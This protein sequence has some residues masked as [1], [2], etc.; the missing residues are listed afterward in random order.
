MK[1]FKLLKRWFNMVTGKSSFHVKQGEGKY[2]SKYEIKGYY[3]DL[4]NKVSNKTVIDSNGIPINTTIANLETYFPIS[5]FQ[6]GLGLY[7]LYIETGEKDYLN[8][9]LRIAEW[10]IENISD[11]GMWDCMGKLNDSAH[12]TQS[13]M[14]QS[15]GVSVLLRAYKE[16]KN[17]K[18]YQNAKLAIDFMLKKVEDGGTALYINDEIIFQEYVSKYNL[19]V[20]NGWIFSIFGLYDFTLVNKEK[21]YIDILNDTIETM[22]LEL[23][24]YD[25][26]FWSNYDLMHTIASPA[27]HD[28]H[29]MQLRI[30]YKLFNKKEFMIYADKWEKYQ[31]NKIY[32][33]LAMIIKLKQKI[34]KNKYYD[35]NTSLV[36]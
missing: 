35:I 5:I 2:F 8:K 4:T 13:S 31:K 21:K 23:K 33:A 26:K 15:E 29:I 19:S 3:N 12:L 11:T 16:T 9:F 36:K 25:R 6:Y 17:E 34:L 18:Y 1:L 24:K 7:D 14:C 10:A 27:Y 28:L 32:R 22:C 30:L 20:L